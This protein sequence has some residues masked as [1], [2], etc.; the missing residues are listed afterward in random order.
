[1]LRTNTIQ[2]KTISRMELINDRLLLT[3]AAYNLSSFVLSL[4]FIIIPN[5][6]FN[7]NMRLLFKHKATRCQDAISKPMN[8]R[9][10]ARLN[11]FLDNMHCKSKSVGFG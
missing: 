11:S 7:C 10:P 8:A 4:S 2:L 9:A 3:S 6:H 1:M 5:K